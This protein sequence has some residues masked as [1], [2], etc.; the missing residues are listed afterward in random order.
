MRYM[1]ILLFFLILPSISAQA[2]LIRLGGYISAPSN[3]FPSFPGLGVSI[4]LI[5]TIRI[6]AGGS[7][8]KNIIAKIVDGLD[9][10]DN[11]RAYSYGATVRL[12]VPGLEIS[13]VLSIGYARTVLDGSGSRFFGYRKSEKEFLTP[14]LGIEAQW[15]NHLYG[16]FELFMTLEKNNAEKYRQE[17]HRITIFDSKGEGFRSPVL[18]NVYL[19][20]LF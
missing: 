5:D 1:L 19:G 16:G 6:E 7:V 15:G 12:R 17:N 2:G 13:P 4:S 10:G 18:P 8:V 9:E 20:F 14:G 11:I 3:P